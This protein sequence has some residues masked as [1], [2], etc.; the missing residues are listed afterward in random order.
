MGA[1]IDELTGRRPT[2]KWSGSLLNPRGN[3]DVVLEHEHIELCATSKALLCLLRVARD[4]LRDSS[5]SAS[6]SA[7]SG[8]RPIPPGA[9]AVS[10]LQD[11]HMR[12]VAPSHTVLVVA[13]KLSHLDEVP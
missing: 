10:H 1:R 8:A 13:L 12:G 5:N 6:R 9:H 2:R 3:G 4:P 7:I 11:G